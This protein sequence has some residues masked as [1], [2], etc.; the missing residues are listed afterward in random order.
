MPGGGSAAVP[1]GAVVAAAV[2]TSAV[3]A[4][5]SFCGYCQI[6]TLVG[7]AAVADNAVC[8]RADALLS[9]GQYAGV[10]FVTYLLTRATRGVHQ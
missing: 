5:S 2:A 1:G 3:V 7:A 9:L 6:F 4:D 8:A 10:I